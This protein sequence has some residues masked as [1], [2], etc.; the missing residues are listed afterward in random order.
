MDSTYTPDDTKDRNHECKVLTRQD[1]EISVP[2]MLKPKVETGH[3]MV[4]CCGEPKIIP[5]PCMPKS[6]PPCP[7]GECCFIL[8]QH[9]SVEIPFD[10]SADVLIAP[11]IIECEATP[12]PPEQKCEPKCE[13]QYPQRRR[14]EVI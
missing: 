12:C 14:P 4:F 13:P 2:V 9:I 3:A 8:S 6:K 5:V 10:I 1:A 7:D 11:P